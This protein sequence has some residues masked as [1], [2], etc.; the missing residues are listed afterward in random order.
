MTHAFREFIERELTRQGWSSTILAA[1]SGLS[2][3]QISKLRKDERDLLPRMP[4]PETIAGLSKAFDLP[5]SEIRRFAVIALGVDG[6]EPP[7][8]IHELKDADD[9]QLF[10]E[11]ATRLGLE[12]TVR[13]EAP[14]KPKASGKGK[15][16]VR[17][18]SGFQPA[19][20]KGTEAPDLE[21][22]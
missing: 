21:H 4:E 11:L 18:A 15:K 19:K 14:S 10:T 20:P 7:T 9:D 12:V 17:H 22:Q 6:I 13:K 5:E 2:A 16:T 3:Q 8:I 1:R